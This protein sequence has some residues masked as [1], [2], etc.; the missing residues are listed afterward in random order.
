M[1]CGEDV[2]RPA[3]R[4]AA[5]PMTGSGMRQARDLRAEETVEVVRNHADGTRFRG[6]HPR[7]RSAQRCAREWT[8]GRVGGGETRRIPREEVEFRPGAAARALKGSEGP[9]VR[10]SLILPRGRIGHGAAP[11]E[12]LEGRRG[13]AQGQGGSGEDH[14]TATT[15]PWQPP[16]RP[17]GRRSARPRRSRQPQ[18]SARARFAV[19]G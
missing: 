18:E 14:R 6:W 9:G 11:S 3:T 16:S 10:T 5:N 19:S 13:D 7:D 15:T 4:N 2:G 8:L 17:S 12:D 1:R